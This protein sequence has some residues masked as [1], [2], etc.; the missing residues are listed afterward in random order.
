MKKIFLPLLLL[1]FVVFSSVKAQTS[2]DQKKFTL[3]GYIVDDVSGETLI[4]ANVICPE[5]Q[6][7]ASTNAYGFF[8]FTLAAGEVV[9]KFSYIGYKTVEKTIQLDRNRELN[10]RLEPQMQLDEVVVLGER[11]ETGINAVQMGAID[12]PLEIIKSTPALFGEADVMKAVQMLPG[13]QS[14]TE[15]MSG[16]HVRGGGPDENLILLDGVP[17]YNVDHMFG[18]F[19]VFTPEAVKKVSLYKGSFP[20][21]FGGRL[22]SVIDVRTND[23]DMKNYHGMLGIGLVSSKF[24]FEGPIKEDQTSFNISGRRSYLDLLAK[25]FMPEDESFSYFFYD[26]NAK[27]NHRFN[28][29]S[30]L[31]LSFYNGRDQM[32]S[33]FKDNSDTYI[34]EDK[35]VLKWGNLSSALRWN[36]QLN[37]KIFSNTTLAYTRYRF[38]ANSITKDKYTPQNLENNYDSEYKSGINDLAANFDFDYHPSPA[39][40]V[41]FGTGYLYHQFNPEVETSRIYNNEDGDVVDTTYQSVGNSRLHAHE[42]SVYAEDNIKLNDKLSINLG[43]HASAFNVQGKTYASLQPRLSAKYQVNN[44]WSFKTAYTQMS[45]Y[46]HL[47]SSYTITMPTD[48][49]VPATKDI[50]PMHAHQYS[51]GGYYTGIKGWEFSAEAYYKDMNNILEYKDG[52]SFMGNSHNW[53]Q[54]VEMGKGRSYG[55][56]LMAQ[57]TIGKTTGWIAYTLA[58]SERKFDKGGINN[59]EWFPYRYD[60]RHHV[61]LTLSHKFSDKI[62]VGAYWEFYTGGTTTLAEEKTVI[63]RPENNSSFYWR[64]ISESEYIQKRNNYRMPSS[65]RLNVGINF[66]KKTKHGMG[67]WSLSVYNIYNAMNPTFLYKDTEYDESVSPAKTKTV[68]KKVTILPF[69]PSVSYTYKF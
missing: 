4:G 44:D 50:K 13:V 24:Q 18:F 26:F 3:S 69:I 48:L 39:H 31:F 43:L 45:Q 63:I 30:R 20:A 2:N 9:L 53:E 67:T 6:T 32:D 46:I 59:G 27:I 62:D 61:N 55:V 22:S 65:H 47:L 11:S 66:H 56:E 14:G 16:I 15:G 35:T 42:L 29:R 36:Y 34:S 17:L 54:K 23:G 1:S 8:S 7:G 51:V 37:S 49:W 60:R 25:P 12:V 33:E 38:L 21:R 5:V 58:K 19:S 64:D 10:I 28:D 57:K 41:K 52:A 40:Q 68:L